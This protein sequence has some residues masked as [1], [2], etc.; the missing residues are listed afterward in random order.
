[1]ETGFVFIGSHQGPHRIVVLSAEGSVEAG[2]FHPRVR[3]S[4]PQDTEARNIY[5]ATMAARREQIKQ[6][7]LQLRDQDDE[8]LEDE[9]RILEDDLRRL[10]S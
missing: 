8:H 1:M 9:A 4:N 6:L 10:G 2:G 7:V 5:E 3:A